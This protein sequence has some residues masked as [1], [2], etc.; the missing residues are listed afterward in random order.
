MEGVFLDLSDA[1]EDDF[2]PDC[3]D[4]ICIETE[5]DSISKASAASSS[6]KKQVSS[7]KRALTKAEIKRLRDCVKQTYHF[8]SIK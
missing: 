3:E 5:S 1:S 2:N 4:E 7:K 6:K 8:F